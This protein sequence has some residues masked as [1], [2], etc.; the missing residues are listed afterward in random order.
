MPGQS[1]FFLL[2]FAASLVACGGDLTLPGDTGG[3]G[4]PTA[5]ETPFDLNL[6]PSFTAGPD[7][8]VPRNEHGH[9]EDGEREVEVDNWA[10]DIA[11]GPVSEAGQAVSFLVD[12][13]EGSEVLAGTPS[14]SSTGTLRYKPGKK[15]GSARVE[16]RLHDDGGTDGG[17]VDTSG[18]HILIITVV[19]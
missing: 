9:D 3:G 8:L 13:S 12:V 7:Q 14:I 17:G 6:A 15:T 16:V 11:P 1:S 2:A 19:D 10:T 18:P 5:P 4:A